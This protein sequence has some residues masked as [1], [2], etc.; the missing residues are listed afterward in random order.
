MK[1]FISSVLKT[2]I[3]FGIG[4]GIVYWTLKGD[5]AGIFGGLLAG[6]LFGIVMSTFVLVQT[7]KFR[8]KNKEISNGREIMMDGVANHFKG[9][10][11]VGGW[12]ILTPDEIIFTSHS[13]NIQKHKTTIQLKEIADLKAVSNLGIIPNGIKITTTSGNK[14]KFVVNNRKKWI[15]K[16][17][18]VKES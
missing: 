18:E 5:A 7:K 9:K 14:E 10:E 15:Q 4:M 8:K 6:L 17:N 12:L 16:I 13:F 11:S 2:G 1:D 3:P